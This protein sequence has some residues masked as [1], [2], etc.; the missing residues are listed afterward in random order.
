MDL[1]ADIVLSAVNLEL[2]RISQ[3]WNSG[4]FAE[5]LQADNFLSAVNLE[6]FRISQVW[7]REIFA[8]DLQADTVS[9]SRAF[10]AFSD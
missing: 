6:P 3:G 1:Q 9:D 5:D 2:L 8:E 10:G 7:S 4:V